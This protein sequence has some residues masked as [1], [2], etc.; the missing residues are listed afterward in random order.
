[1]N[2]Q[3]INEKK[4]LM[5]SDELMQLK[6]TVSSETMKASFNEIIESIKQSGMPDP[7]LGPGDSE[8][9][10]V[11][12]CEATFFTKASGAKSKSELARVERDLSSMKGM[13]IE[14]GEK[15]S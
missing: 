6:K 3:Q 11:E 2:A 5:D 13:W 12:L 9:K 4:L 10:L 7:G 14:G 8:K 1:M 15:G